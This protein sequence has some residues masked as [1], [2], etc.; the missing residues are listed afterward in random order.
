MES[1]INLSELRQESW[2]RIQGL[3][4]G[5]NPSLPLLE[6]ASLVQTLH[7]ALNRML[8]LHGIAAHSWGAPAN[9][10]LEWF[11]REELVDFLTEEEGEFL[12]HGRG[13]V[14]LFKYQVEG[15]WALAWAVGVIPSLAL[16]PCSDDFVTL[17]PEILTK[18]STKTFRKKCRLRDDVEIV[19]ECDFHYCVHWAMVDAAL[20]NR[21]TSIKISTID[22]AERRRA[23]EWLI[24]DEGWYEISLDT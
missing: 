20:A 9:L 1:K 22:V 2:E 8:C 15:I 19:K 18:E 24:G 13:D 11:R 7:D 23:L 21:P 12:Y 17:L 14:N 16:Y 6:S 4:L 5:K 10:V 3:R